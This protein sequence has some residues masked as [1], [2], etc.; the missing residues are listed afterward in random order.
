[1][2]SKVQLLGGS[3]EVVYVTPREETQ[4]PKRS[5]MCIGW[6]STTQPNNVTTGL[7]IRIIQ[8]MIKDKTQLVTST[9]SVLLSHPVFQQTEQNHRQLMIE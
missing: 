6:N 7:T 9:A 2:T 1:M 8:S 5:E 3:S 4:C